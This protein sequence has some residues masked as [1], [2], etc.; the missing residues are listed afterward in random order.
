MID[1]HTHTDQSD[2]TLSPPEL[3]E[4][5]CAASLDALAITD[6][7]TFSGYELALPVARAR[8]LDLVWGIE[9]ST[10]YRGRSVHLL[11][12][13]FNAGPTAAFRLW[14]EKLQEG[15]HARNR[16]LL[17]SLKRNGL[18]ITME[19]LKSRGRNL[20]GRPHFAAL[21]LEKGYVQ[22]IQEAF[23]KYLAEGGKC[24]VRRYEPAFEEAVSRVTHAGGVAS[25]AHPVRLSRDDST[26]RRYVGEMKELG[27][28][29]IEVFHSDHS[30]ADTR[31]HAALAGE[32]GLA[33]T[34]GSD[35]HGATKPRV[36]LASV[37]VPTSLLAELQRRAE[38]NSRAD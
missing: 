24:H 11:A 9:L 29:A 27:L 2:G 33:Q 6:H 25:V 36:A 37:K 21:M 28:Q 15:R 8:G 7:D 18:E 17:E 22:S 3:V 5:A 32:F 31:R 20:P 16:L 12:Y 14:I 35:F 38:V 23:D 34:G 13:F 4:A 10:T 19:E 26:L 30:E 1:L